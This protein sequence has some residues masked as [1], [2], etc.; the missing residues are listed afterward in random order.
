LCTTFPKTSTFFF[1]AVRAM[2]VLVISS[3]I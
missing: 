1:A 3:Y 2:D